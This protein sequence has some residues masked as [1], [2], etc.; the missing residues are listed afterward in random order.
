MAGLLAVL[1]VPA[2]ADE[3]SA[4][5][6]FEG[7]AFTASRAAALVAH[8]GRDGEWTPFIVVFTDFAL[9][10]KDVH[11]SLDRD[12]AIRRQAERAN[13]NVFW[14]SY[15]QADNCHAWAFASSLLMDPRFPR[16]QPDI[17]SRQ[18]FPGAG[19]STGWRVTGSCEGE[20]HAWRGEWTAPFRA[21]FDLPVQVPP[22]QAG[23]NSETGPQGPAAALQA[24]MK[25]V[26]ERDL[27]T[28]QRH[29][30]RDQWP[31]DAGDPRALDAY[32]RWL[33]H[34]YPS[35]A[36]VMASL[37]TP[38][39]AR[40]DIEGK[41]DGRRVKGPVNLR[42]VDDTWKITDAPLTWLEWPWDVER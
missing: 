36:R 34:A 19:R 42:R 20:I 18:Q 7:I 5:F 16:Q 41:K 39:A 17:A 2:G 13:G 15:E 14:V 21:T 10:M 27:A 4:T 40:L 38:S 8:Q 9:D 1:A 33:R 31:V 28:V 26:A 22:A 37:V 12:T 25:A 30:S 24:F 6:R 11:D 35:E 23:P 32:F 3:F 29:I